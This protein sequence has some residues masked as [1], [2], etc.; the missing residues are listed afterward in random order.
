MLHEHT[1]AHGFG[2]VQPVSRIARAHETAKGVG[3]LAVIAYV[4]HFITLVNVLK[5]YLVSIGKR[6]DTKFVHV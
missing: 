1:N 3:A 4:H 6:L 5:N 2:S